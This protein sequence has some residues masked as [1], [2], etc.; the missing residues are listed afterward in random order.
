M[1]LMKALLL[2][3]LLG[4]SLSP[5][6]APGAEPATAPPG[7]RTGVT[8]YVSKLGDNSDGRS[9][10][11]AFHTIQA[12]LSAVPDDRGGH[13]LI[14]RPDT[15]DEAN[16]YP[17]HKG[18][19]GAY[20][21]LEGDWDGR[22]GSGTNGWVVIDS[23]A[24][25]VVVR[26][27]AK[28]PTGNP[29]FMILAG[30][31][32]DQETGLKSVDWWG[33]WRCD[34][35]YSGVAWDRWIFRR[36]YATGSEGG[37]GWD[38]TSQAGC[39]FSAVVEDCV[40]LG[41]FAGAAVMGHVNRPA[42]PVVFRRSYMMCLDVWGDA[43]GAYV[44]AHNKTMP[45]TPDAVFEDCTIIGPDNALQ[46][47][48]PGFQGYTRVKFK[49]CRLIVLNFSQP[50]GTP[51]TGILYSDVAGKYLHVDLEDCA[52]VGYKVFGARNGD[53][54]SYTATG[55]NRAYV[56]YRQPVPPEI[57]R[58][59]FWP[60]EVFNDLLPPRFHAPA[61]REAVRPRL[62]KLPF[63]LGS[64]MENTPVVFGSRRLL[65]LD[66]RE[67]TKN[68]TDDYTK[69]MY[70]YILDLETG[71]E[72][73]RFGEGHS[74][75]NAFVNGP[76]LHV[77]ASQGSNR[78]W[79]QSLD[80]F[81]SRDLKTWKRELAVPRE[82]G[83]HLFNASVCRDAEGF[84]MAYESD[85]PVQFCFKFAR[86]KDLSRWKKVDGRVFTG[87]NHEYSACPVIRYFAPY[88]YVIYLHAVVPGHRGW[89]SFL[90]RSKDLA[91]WELSPFN[92]ILEAGPGEGE[93][94][95]D[96]DLFESEG[97]TY[98]YY[99]TGDQQTWGAL[100]VAMYPGPMGEFFARH[101]PEGL[102]TI[103]ASARSD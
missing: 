88:Y 30:G 18:A 57:E 89:I 91:A 47:G 36:L 75:A 66:H 61:S 79:F 7:A 94:N 50:H 60:V 39:E 62:I 58:L 93:N 25:R 78:D 64:A 98:L 70:L 26:T 73:C 65:V 49:G 69:S 23:G 99:A 3:S 59:R 34:P 87:V 17:A 38:M 44:R 27:N 82:A 9:W 63:A 85:R 90:A 77:F 97:N 2:L 28:A 52:L 54:F 55:H 102:P 19:A 42:E 83:E 31:D 76:E 8:L 33:P 11:R 71:R 92:P 15:Y 96:V 6:T 40:A 20:N 21:I 84:L 4:A 22:L 81:S 29:T 16:L 51:S 80:H 13:R 37:I 32:P 67:D 10:P 74:F 86:S 35:S 48:Y 45:Q 1:A 68:K 56:Q 72:V 41:R 14:V 43:G 103:K 100:R 12:A 24:P 46:V 5:L 95:S 101:F 53:L